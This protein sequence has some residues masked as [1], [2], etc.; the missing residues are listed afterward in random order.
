MR[1]AVLDPVVVSTNKHGSSP[2]A[3]G[4]YHQAKVAVDVDRFIP[5]CVGR[6]RNRPPTE[7]S[8]TVHPH[9]RGAV[10][11]SGRPKSTDNGSSPR[12]WGGLVLVVS[13]CLP[14]R[15]IPT[16]VGRLWELNQAPSYKSVHPHVRGAVYWDGYIKAILLGSSP[17]AWGGSLR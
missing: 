12:A 7:P 17:R 9:V 3:W 13:T 15:F 5:T 1:G 14:E 6:L 8:G 11:K 4:G 2:R 10:V 16:C